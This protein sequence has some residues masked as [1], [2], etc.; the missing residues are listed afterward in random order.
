MFMHS[1]ADIL[2]VLGEQV[3]EVVQIAVIISSLLGNGDKEADQEQDDADGNEDDGVLESAPE[4]LPQCLLSTLSGHFIVF[5]V[6]EVDKWDDQ[7]T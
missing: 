2:T 7:E 5:F 6:P 1:D 3:L 4:A